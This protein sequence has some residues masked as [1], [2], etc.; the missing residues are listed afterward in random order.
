MGALRQPR[1]DQPGR[2]PPSTET[3]VPKRDQ[4][5]RDP[6]TPAERLRVQSDYDADTGYAPMYHAALADLPRLSSG[7]VCYAFVLVVNMLSYGRGK[8][9]AGKRYDTTLPISTLELAELCRANVRDIQR[10]VDELHERGMIRV[11]RVGR[12]AGTKYLVSL[13]YRE[14]RKLEDYSV[15]KRRQAVAIDE[16]VE[17]EPEDD[18][19]LAIT[20]DAVRLVKA[21]SVRPGKASKAVKVNV[22]VREFSVQN[23][24]PRVDVRFDAVVQSGRLVVSASFLPAV[25]GEVKG[26]EKANVKRHVCRDTPT[27]GGSQIPTYAGSISALFDPL[28]KKSGSR[29]L[30]PDRSSLQAA[31]AEQGT[32]PHDFLVHY[33]M[34]QRASR[35][36]SGPKVVA[37]IVKDARAHWEKQEQHVRASV[38]RCVKC[39][40]DVSEKMT[41]Q[42]RCGDCLSG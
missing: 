18:E 4:Y 38:P 15:W 26:E 14:W 37:S 10:Q 20:K 30:S 40:C 17:D 42:G 7:A 1:I 33:V 21:R 11:K 32:M 41:I 9:K 16:A 23:D 12:G 5:G 36:I 34:T 27:N 6:D 24:S 19:P 22:G 28:L 35:P 8:D 3:S 29:L 31:C 39:G 25:Q 13:L 2:K